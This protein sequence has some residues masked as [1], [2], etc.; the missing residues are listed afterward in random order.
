[1]ARTRIDTR[2]F[3]DESP[4][5]SYQILTFILCCLAM[6]IDGYDVQIIGVAA[7]GIRETLKLEP[8]TLGVVITAGQVG[9]ALGALFLAPASDW[10]GRKWLMVVCC[11]VFGVFSFSTAFAST[12]PALVTLRVL[13]GIGLGGIGPAALALGSEHA[14]KR[15]KASIPT[16]IWTA[17]PVGGMGAGFSAVYLLPLGGW[18]ALFIAAGVVP[19]VL[20]IVFA[21]F[22]PESIVF[23]GARGAGQE[24]IH[25]IARKIAPNLPPDA[26][27]YTS[28]EKRPGVPLKHLF[29]ERR[30]LGTILLWL[31]FFL[32]Y[33]ILV[34]FLSW[35]PTMIKMTTGSTTELGTSLAFWNIGSIVCGILIGRA[36]DKVGY[37]RVLPWTFI[38]IAL[39][40]WAIGATLTAPFWLLLCAI[41]LQGGTAGGS[42]NALM[43]LAA[44]SYPAAVRSTGVGY[45]YAIGG[46]AGAFLAPL[47]GGFLLQMHWTPSAMCYLAGAPV[48][49]GT[50]ALL[51]LRTQ[52]HFRKGAP[53]ELA[54]AP[55]PVAG[56]VGGTP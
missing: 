18:P 29:T 34:F 32:D 49:L 10:I 8:A 33:G 36:V 11:G 48:L 39:S 54:P 25:K 38:I 43:A 4:Y 46:R 9:V 22:L 45:A 19:L 50:V 13:A 6:V 37:Y 52:P 20:M 28:E 16:W 27:L 14:P 51:I 2:A 17:L 24:R 44:N 30:A 5:G 42:G 23:L 41:T 53:E 1:M 3:I 47:A 12:V 56:V 40:M 31:L 55:Q 7:A 15:F 21:L 26:I 35:V